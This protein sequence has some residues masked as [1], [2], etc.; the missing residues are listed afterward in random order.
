MGLG[1]SGVFAAIAVSQSL[2]A[3]VGVIVFR[4]GKWKGREI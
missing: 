2:L 1:P 4:R 3:V